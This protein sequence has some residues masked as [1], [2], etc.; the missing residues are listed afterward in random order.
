MANEC[1]TPAGGPPIPL[2][3]DTR[4]ALFTALG[5]HLHAHAIPSRSKVT[6]VGAGAVGLAA[7]FAILNQGVASELALVDV[8]VEP[9]N[10]GGS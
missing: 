3:H 4:R 2:D 10:Q 5:G 6:I 8:S 7:A 9:E 1:S